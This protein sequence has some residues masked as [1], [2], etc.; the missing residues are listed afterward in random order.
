MIKWLTYTLN[1][2]SEAPEGGTAIQLTFF[3]FLLSAKKS[4]YSK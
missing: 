2:L 1:R 3:V 4:I